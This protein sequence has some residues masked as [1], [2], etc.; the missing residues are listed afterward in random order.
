[1]DDIEM[2]FGLSLWL[3][4]SR[5]TYLQ[6]AQ[7]PKAA[8]EYT[9]RIVRS[10]KKNGFVA[11]IAHY[12]NQQNEPTMSLS[13][14]RA[15]IASRIGHIRAERA[16]VADYVE[17]HVSPSLEINTNQIANILRFESAGSVI[18]YSE[19]FVNLSHLV[20][21]KNDR[22]LL[23][24]IKPILKDLV[25]LFP[26]KR[27]KML[28]F[29]LGELE[30]DEIE[31]IA[32]RC[33]EVMDALD[34][35]LRRT[36]SDISV[37]LLALSASA[38]N[39][40]LT[41]VTAR[42]ISMR[43]E[44]DLE[45]TSLVMKVL[46]GMR[47]LILASSDRVEAA[48]YLGKIALNLSGHF[49]GRALQAFI[50]RELLPHG[51]GETSILVKY[52]TIGNSYV[53]PLRSPLSMDTQIIH[54]WAQLNRRLYGDQLAVRR[55]ESL[56]CGEV[57]NAL[58][59]E[60]S[61]EEF[62]L[63]IAEVT[64]L[65]ADFEA[66]LH[67]AES[68]EVSAS[69]YYQRKGR[70][71]SSYC[72]LQ[73]GRIGQSAERLTNSYLVTGFD[74]ALNYKETARR[75]LEDEESRWRG[76]ISTPILLDIYAKHIG[77]EFEPER[78]YAYED[79]LFENSI[80]RPS[81]LAEIHERFE[82]SKLVYFLRY[83]AIES[84]MDES[85]TVFSGS[86]DIAEER[87]AVCRLLLQLDPIHASE[88]QAEIRQI[89]GRLVL[90]D[91][92]RDIQRSKIYVDSEA[93]KKKIG[94]N[95]RDSFDR[96]K[97]FRFRQASELSV[98][99]DSVESDDGLTSL[100]ILPED[101]ALEIFESIV[102][103]LRDQ[104]VSS[105]EHGLDGYL[106]VRIR[107]GTLAGELRGPLESANLL[108]KR[109][110][111]TGG[112]K[113][114]SNL[115][116][117]TSPHV[118]KALIAFTASFDALINEMTGE[119]IQVKR[120]HDGRGMLD[121]TLTTLVTDFLGA[122]VTELTTF[123]EFVENLFKFFYT[124]LDLRL[125]KL[126]FAVGVTAKARATSLLTQLIA[127]LEAHVTR[128]D[129]G[130]LI[131]SVKTAQTEMQRVFDRVT[132]WFR[133][134]SDPTKEPFSIEDAI[135]ISRE[136]ISTFTRGIDTEL[137]IPPEARII[138]MGRFL[139]S[140]VD[141]LSI[142]FE[143]ILR[144][145]GL[146]KRPVAKIKVDYTDSVIRIIV[147]NE[148]ADMVDTDESKNSIRLIKE[149]MEDNQY[150]RSISKEGGTGFHKIW[151]IL[152]YD[153]SPKRTIEAPYLDFGFKDERTFFVAFDIPAI[154]ENLHESAHN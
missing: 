15:T 41:E 22:E 76:N 114:S 132:E 89:I 109:D 58:Q 137:V 44:Q 27:I 122:A 8:V 74:S 23:P 66:A 79:F 88:Y 92:V 146:E 116:P 52:A 138:F 60:L 45:Q 84:T 136:S 108:T 64:I 129:P 77:Q 56:A 130:G 134:S 26:E 65:Q 102:V 2:Y 33:S 62:A 42:L 83:I 54:K 6:L 50:T 150:G 16:D 67:A 135:N 68:L 126:R 119:W 13:S 10:S 90:K 63:L 71:I 147:E 104:F 40:D 70:I 124:V 59:S 91:R 106:S 139:T 133:L 120:N 95:L 87:I 32:D 61:T 20:V 85:L 81:E 18:D 5:I 145:S 111:I 51:S 125:E 55:L 38:D 101:E 48:S 117:S 123:D 69:A 112:Y 29:E 128:G 46:A 17:F 113:V 3:I 19:T 25:E 93:I 43:S 154:K 118:A 53:S 78:R 96:Y 24:I 115:P 140:F 121:F 21:A 35:F 131:R 127:D 100:L 97:A 143:N 4:K 141:I 86:R 57:N 110:S 107:H 142:V 105:N 82:R 12:F 47:S 9:K 37:P 49:W 152:N 148:I 149:A 99:K 34:A 103:Q 39:F 153:F 75:L 73:L 151:K 98:L 28:L 94:K 80:Q 36:N 144:H 11:F 14:F 72:L 1:L 30:V 7:G 31:K